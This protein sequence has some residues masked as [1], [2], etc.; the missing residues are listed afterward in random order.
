MFLGS[1]SIAAE[2]QAVDSI[3]AMLKSDNAWTLA[4]QRS[5]C[6]IPAPP[7]KEAT[8]ATEFARRLRALGLSPRID[9]VGNVIAERPGTGKGP[10]IVLAGHLDTVFPEGTDVRVREEN[11]GGRMKGP[12]IADN[13][14]GLA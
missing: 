9:A 8:R 12:G 7:F 2:A 13:C 5:I 4:Q 11:G 1:V 10:T 3:L 6:E 14:R